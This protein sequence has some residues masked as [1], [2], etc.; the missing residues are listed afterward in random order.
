MFISFLQRLAA[1]IRQA[2]S[3]VDRARSRRALC[4]ILMFD[5]HLLRDIGL[6]R[7]DVI[8]CLSTPSDDDPVDL[9][10]ARRKRNA[11][12]KVPPQPAEHRCAA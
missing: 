10:D 3:N 1:G 4:G 7:A 12:G 2:V 9:L 11:S 5:D 6:T 8:D